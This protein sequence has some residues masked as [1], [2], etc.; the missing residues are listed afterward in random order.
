MKNSI[1]LFL[2]MNTLLSCNRSDDIVLNIKNLTLN[3]EN[4]DFIQNTLMM[5]ELELINNSP[6]ELI[7]TASESD[8]IYGKSRLILMDTISQESIDIFTGNVFILKDKTKKSIYG[9]INLLSVEKN[10]HFFYGK[11]YDYKLIKDYDY[12]LKNLNSKL[13]LC[14]IY[15]IQNEKDLVDIDKTGYHNIKPIKDTL[16]INSKLFIK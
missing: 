4:S 15:Y 1:I 2:L 10:Q 14:K 9:S 12:V 6:N 11:N 5:F 8:Y 16:K 7:F 3:T 13:K